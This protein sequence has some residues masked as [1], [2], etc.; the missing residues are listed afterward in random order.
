[1]SKAER[2][3]PILLTKDDVCKYKHVCIY[4]LVYDICVHI[5][6][7]CVLLGQNNIGMD[8]GHRI[9]IYMQDLRIRTVFSIGQGTNAEVLAGK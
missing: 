6:H 9:L 5:V 8:W 4:V 7:L 3:Q 2:L 1:M